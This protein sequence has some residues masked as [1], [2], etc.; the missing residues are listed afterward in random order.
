LH[1]VRERVRVIEALLAPDE[2]TELR[3]EWIVNRRDTVL[4]PMPT[5]LLVTFTREEILD[6]VSFLQAPD[7]E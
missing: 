7:G 4:S 3:K 6:L 1:H 5:G 2:V